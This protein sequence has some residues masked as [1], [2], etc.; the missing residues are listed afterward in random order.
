MTLDVPAQL[1][2][3]SLPGRKQPLELSG[4]A[5]RV[6]KVRGGGTVIPGMPSSSG[7]LTTTTLASAPHGTV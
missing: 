3:P 2:E 1:P 7:I 6:R 5:R 4:G